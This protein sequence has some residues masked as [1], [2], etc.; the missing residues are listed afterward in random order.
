[1]K[2]MA[3]G[4]RSVIFNMFPLEGQRC[5]GE[6]A[7]TPER[8]SLPDALTDI[9]GRANSGLSVVLSPR[10]LSGRV[11]DLLFQFCSTA[12]IERRQRVVYVTAR[13][14]VPPPPVAV[15]RIVE[16]RLESQLLA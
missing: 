8:D 5:P 7:A 11:R 13:R 2:T 15:H 12:A 3:S 6:I 16:S 9:N 1:M 10:A 14:L 4:S